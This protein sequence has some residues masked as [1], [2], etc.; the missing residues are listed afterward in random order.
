M[1]FSKPINRE[2]DIDGNTF[3]VS[4]DNNGIDFRVKGKRKTAHVNW[5]RV[6]EIAEGEDGSSASQVLGISS[7][8]QTESQEQPFA[9][10]TL[11]D[12]QSQATGSQQ[13]QNSSGASP[14]SSG[15]PRSE[16]SSS[17]NSSSGNS[18]SEPSDQGELG[19]AVTAGEIGPES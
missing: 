19:R 4:F 9:P 17:E 14:Q 8:N 6:L 5:N 18:S 2:I 13:T 7:G 12:N 15:A 1:K 3:I 11:S 10:Q 16:N